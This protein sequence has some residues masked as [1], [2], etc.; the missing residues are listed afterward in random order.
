MTETEITIIMNKVRKDQL[1]VFPEKQTFECM[2][3]EDDKEINM[4][5]CYNCHVDYC[6]GLRNSIA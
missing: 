4:S 2:T 5:R 3:N 6:N 1:C